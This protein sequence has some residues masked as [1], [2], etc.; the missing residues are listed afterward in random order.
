LAGTW[1]RRDFL[2]LVGA[3]AVA[4]GMPSLAHAAA[5]NRAMNVLFIAVDDLRPQL[6][7]YGHER[8]ISPHIDRLAAGG[9][10]F[11]YAYCQQA[12]CAP[13]RASLLT[14]LR[15]DSTTIYDLQTPVSRHLPNVLTLPQHFRSNGYTSISLGKIYHHWYDDLAGWNERPW[16]A[17]GP[18][19]QIPENQALDQYAAEMSKGQPFRNRGPATEAADEDYSAYPDGKTADK[20]IEMLNALKDGPFFLAVG[21]LKPH[22]PFVAPKS[23]WDLYDPADIDLAD[24][25]FKPK[26]C[27]NIAMHTWG[28]LRGY[29]GIPASGPLRPEHARHL[30]HGYYACTSYTD[31][32]V[33]RVVGELDRLGLRE[34]TAIVL[35]G[36]HGWNLGEHGLW[37]KHCNFETS[38]H[39]PMIFSVPGM[40]GNG[41]H[42]EALTEFVDIYPTLADVCGLSLP[43]HLQG[44]SLRPLLEDPGAAW[45]DAAYSQYP[46][47][48]RMGYSMRTRRYRYTEWVEPDKKGVF[49]RE[50][51]DHDEDPGENVSLAL[52][53]EYADL[54]ERLSAQMRRELGVPAPSAE[55]G[56]G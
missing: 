12:V 20:A 55:G 15:P 40:A 26:D 28:E 9:V 51:Y 11:E 48:P 44:K 52:R 7:C 17:P 37:C 46:R 43:E 27:P 34:N 53:P 50:L 31:A 23:Y 1:N 19:Y 18:E 2:K 16:H 4:A 22:L 49:A 47:G 33:G 3:G 21:L 38:V 6:G 35:W 56:A 25:P 5:G 10:L 30:I 41:R 13:S 54:I 14:G 36:D 42:S 39:S 24:N 32:M 29:Y 8:M 45:D